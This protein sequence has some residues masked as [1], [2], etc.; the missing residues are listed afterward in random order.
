MTVCSFW[1]FETAS[2]FGRKYGTPSFSGIPFED[3]SLQDAGK[4]QTLSFSTER[5]IPS[6]CGDNQLSVPDGTK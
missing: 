3:A 2:S 6:E 5:Y 1:A 4:E